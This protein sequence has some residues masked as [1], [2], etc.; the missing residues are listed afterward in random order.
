VLRNSA[1]NGT[2]NNAEADI[3]CFHR[4]CRGLRLGRDAA[5]FL[6]KPENRAWLKR[7]AVSRR[8]TVL[9]ERTRIACLG[10]IVVGNEILDGRCKD[11]HVGAALAL[12]MEWNIS[13]TYTLFLPDAADVLEDQFR[14]AMARPHPFFCCGGIGA[15]PDDL[16]RQ[17][18]A[19]AL[20]VTI[21]RHAEAV[22]ILKQQFGCRV[23]EARLR[24]VDFP[25]GAALVPNPVN[26]V[27]GFHVANGYFLPGFPEMAGPMMRWV[28]EARYEKAGQ[29]LRREL[30]LPGA[31]EGDIADLMTAFVADHPDV[32]F[33]SLPRFTPA[34]TQVLLANTGPVAAVKAAHEDLKR[35]LAPTCVEF[36]ECG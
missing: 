20:G 26:R 1:G 19:K 11:R 15:T 2:A 29:R 28:L 16:T 3:S 10:L 7:I 12:C 14:W 33:S 27:P 17:S 9:Q 22:A 23:N 6:P 30:L 8:K 24:M 5:A 34:G 13:L 25:A 18:A 21:E 36:E 32:A 31:R 35:R 4:L